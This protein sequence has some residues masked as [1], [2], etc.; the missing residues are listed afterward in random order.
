PLRRTRPLRL[1]PCQKQ[2][3]TQPAF[4]PRERLPLPIPEVAFLFPGKEHL[5]SRLSPGER[6]Y[7][8][9]VRRDLAGRWAGILA[10]KLSARRWRPGDASARRLRNRAVAE[11][12]YAHR[13]CATG[14]RN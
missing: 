7:T 11:F 4:R 3:T 5:L 9:F 1:G 2:T 13:R 6:L 8:V 10:L 14:S 12:R